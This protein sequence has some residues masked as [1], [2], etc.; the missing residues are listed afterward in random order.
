MI[1]MW[2]TRCVHMN[3][4]SISTVGRREVAHSLCLQRKTFV[5]FS[6]LITR[7]LTAYIKMRFVK[8]KL[9]FLDH[10]AGIL[11]KYS[12]ENRSFD[13]TL[14]NCIWSCVREFNSPFSWHSKY[15]SML[16]ISLHNWLNL[17]MLQKSV[18]I[19]PVT[20]WAGSPRIALSWLTSCRRTPPTWADQGGWI[21]PSRWSHPSHFFL[22][23]AVYKTTG[24]SRQMMGECSTWPAVANIL[25]SEPT[26]RTSFYK[27]SSNT[28]LI[29]YS[30][31]GAFSVIFVCK[32]LKYMF[33]LSLFHLLIQA[34]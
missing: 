22:K 19:F 6:S 26:V 7:N 12:K 14:R 27:V 20:R 28:S 17:F 11:S 32:F 15:I 13:K 8:I 30:C 23:S 9:L 3:G 18:R 2:A 1:G 25:C 4:V 34:V 29:N 21:W 24:N 31:A 10:L 5:H 33:A 16:C